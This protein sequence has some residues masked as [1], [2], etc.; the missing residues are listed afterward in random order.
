MKRPVMAIISIA[1]ILLFLMICSPQSTLAAST[2]TSLAPIS[3]TTLQGSTGGQPVS[4]LALKDQSGTQDNLSDY[5]SFTTPSMIYNGFRTYQVPARISPSS[6]ISFQIKVNYK[7]PVQSS[8]RWGW[9]L[10]NWMLKTWTNV[11]DNSPVTSATAWTS[12]SFSRTNVA[13]FMDGTGKI[14]LLLQSGNS[15]GN[16]KLDYESISLTYNAPFP[17][18]TSK[19]E[20]D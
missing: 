19:S 17:T 14:R 18:P 5:V 10:Y 8:Q 11:G 2:S 6:V 13:P 7:G 16:A 3:I 12:L 9:S 4:A 1:L 20:M 15:T